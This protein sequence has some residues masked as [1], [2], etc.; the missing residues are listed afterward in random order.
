MS[1]YEQL[2]FDLI[3]DNGLPDRLVECPKLR[4][5]VEFLIDHGKELKGPDG[6]YPHMGRRKVV[7]IQCKSF[8][9]LLDNL[10]ALL[11]EIDD[12]FIEETGQSQSNITIASDVW[13]ARSKKL[14]G[15]S[16]IFMHPVTLEVY[17]VPIALLP[18]SGE[19]AHELAETSMLGL[20]RAGIKHTSLY[21]SVNDN[22]KTAVKT[23]R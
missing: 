12:W 18:P 7:T 2:L 3:N 8:Q 16:V 23:G 5:L 11:K 14:L 22:C 15:L 20:E 9:A 4:K 17:R 19:K 6:S 1:K 21:R 10:K 13:D